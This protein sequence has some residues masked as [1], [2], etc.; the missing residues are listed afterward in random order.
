MVEWQASRDADGDFTCEQPPCNG[1]EVHWV[2]HE[3]LFYIKVNGERVVYEV[4]RTEWAVRAL[5]SAFIA[6]Q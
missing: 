5:V 2:P 4:A 6:S 1:V 3:S